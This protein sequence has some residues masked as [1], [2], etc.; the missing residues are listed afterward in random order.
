MEMV[1]CFSK[2]AIIR[3]LVLLR[4]ALP[5]LGEAG[6]EFP[7]FFSCENGLIG[8]DRID[9]VG[10]VALEKNVHG[11]IDT[12]GQVSFLCI[13]APGDTNIRPMGRLTLL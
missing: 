4:G 3:V 7:S 10:H 6:E 9:H 5:V 2:G 8:F 12:E 1:L 11:R 13:L